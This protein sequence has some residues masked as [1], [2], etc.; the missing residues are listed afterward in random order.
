MYNL[1]NSLFYNNPFLLVSGEYK[2]Y[3]F[4]AQISVSTKR[5]HKVYLLA[6]S[7]CK[8]LIIVSV[9]FEFDPIYVRRE[10]TCFHSQYQ[11]FYNVN[12]VLRCEPF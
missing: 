10:E 11:T 7:N 2:H 3:I 12:Q 8:N 4:P 6:L 1:Q 5:V 9:N